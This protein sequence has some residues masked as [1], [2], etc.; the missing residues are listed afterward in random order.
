MTD[1]AMDG[2]ALTGHLRAPLVVGARE[3]AVTQ[4]MMPV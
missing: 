1:Q 4:P 3:M 2:W